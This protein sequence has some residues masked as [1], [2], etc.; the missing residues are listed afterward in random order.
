MSARTADHVIVGGGSAGCV[1]ASRLS[2]APDRRVLLLE[3]GPPD[4]SFWLRMPGGISRVVWGTT[5]SWAYRSEPEPHLG[6]RVLG[7]P[8]GRVLGGSSSINGM[9]WLRGHPLDFDRWAQMGATGWSHDDV[10]PAFRKAETAPVDGPGRGRN[11]P[12]RLTRPRDDTPLTRAFLDA[13]Q[14]AGYPLAEDFNG[15]DPEGFGVF[16]RSTHEGRR[17][18]ASRA[19]LSRDVRARAN[20]T[21]KTGAQALE[22]ILDHGRATGVRY[23]EDGQVREVRAD[24]GV[25]VAAGAIGS[26][27]LLQVSGIGPA[28][29]LEKAGI[30]VQHDLPGVGEN[31]NDHPDIVLQWACRKPVTLFPVTRAP[32]NWLAGAEWML[33]GTGPAATNHFEA[34]AF[35]RSRPDVE[36]PDL[37]FT[38]MPLA[39]VPG[40]TEIL[41]SHAFQVHIDLLRPSSRGHVRPRSSDPLEAPAITFNYLADPQDRAT[42]RRAVALLR[43]VIAQP[44]LAGFAEGE[45][46]PGAG[47]TDDGALDAWIAET[48]ETCYHPVGTCRMGAA[49]DP[50]AV[51]DPTC[52]VR[53]LDGLHVIDA[54][55]MPS[56]VSANTNAATIMLAEHAAGFLRG[57]PEDAGSPARKPAVALA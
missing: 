11:G 12:M 44:A 8:R 37:Q 27:H 17:W 15:P 41:R 4:R 47:L 36:H 48:M 13:G 38:F 22:L 19:Y 30:A 43:E 39:V 10:L 50:G 24:A 3:A 35:I 31:L 54:S 6:G 56:I 46:Y 23:L 42:F 53:G 20:L 16:E 40:G 7:H 21:V 18:S 2:E 45:I 55:I 5:Y 49:D 29:T 26:P 14:Q 25:I 52:R 28:R 51:V 33:R 34:G 9:V 32:R 57:G 1:L